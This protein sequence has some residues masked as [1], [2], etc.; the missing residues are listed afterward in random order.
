MVVFFLLLFQLLITTILLSLTSYSR[1]T[2]LRGDDESE[3][4]KQHRLFGQL[5]NWPFPISEM[6]ADDQLTNDEAQ[7]E[8]DSPN[9][10]MLFID[11]IT[12]KQRFLR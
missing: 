4:A 3:I 7:P 1:A 5:N 6:F 9:P 12:L 11:D 2:R 8:P 10:E